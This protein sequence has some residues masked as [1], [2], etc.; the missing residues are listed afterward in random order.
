MSTKTISVVTSLYRSAPYITEFYTRARAA[1][2]KLGCDYEFIL[3]NDGSP[4]DALEK[5]VALHLRD[6]KVKVIDLSRNFG[7]QPAMITGVEH[8][9]G[10]YIFTLDSDLEEEPEHL[11]KFL[12]ILEDSKGEVDLV[13]GVRD[14]RD[15]TTF[16]RLTSFL[17]YQ[18]L[19]MMG[20]L[21][22]HKNV[23]FM[24]LMTK[25][26]AQALC[27]FP[28]KHFFFA[29]MVETTGFK[30]VPIS[31]PKSYK[32]ST[33]YSF[34]KRL[35]TAIEGIISFTKKPLTFF[36]MIGLCVSVVSFMMAAYLVLRTLF[37]GASIPGWASVMVSIWFLGGL[38][39]LAIG[40]VGLYVGQIYEQVKMRPRT[41]IR[42]IYGD[43]S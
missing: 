23:L 38:I 31:L 37:G 39:L 20:G 19:H 3:V 25:R 18:F 2:E 16:R 41:I 32:G 26:Y 29:G 36:V 34:W 21:K 17:F 28:E 9:K 35:R 30:Q 14:A 10:D 12:C 1:V 13:Y 43:N 40:V 33:S 42:H 11:E 8:A 24:R 15:D 5:A 4:D 22:D 7:Q 27:A 6:N